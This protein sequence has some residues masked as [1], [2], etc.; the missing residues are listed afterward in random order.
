[1]GSGVVS[2]AH[3]FLARAPVVDAV[4]MFTLP[5]V[6]AVAAALTPYLVYLISGLHSSPDRRRLLFC[7]LF[8]ACIPHGK[9]AAAYLV[10]PSG[11]I[12]PF[13]RGLRK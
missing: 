5:L 13:D 7:T 6:S 8:S 4:L 3:Y 2:S 9:A 1:M 10:I 12:R 11:L